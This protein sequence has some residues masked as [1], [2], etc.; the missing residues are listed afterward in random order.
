MPDE[1]VSEP[2]SSSAAAA[3]AAVALSPRRKPVGLII[4]YVELRTERRNQ[5]INCINQPNKRAA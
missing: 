1:L 2:S 5:Q 3:V 4:Y